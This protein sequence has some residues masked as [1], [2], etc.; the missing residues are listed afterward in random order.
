MR[1]ACLGFAVA[2]AAACGGGGSGSPAA[3][4]PIKVSPVKSG[5]SL[6][7]LEL[8]GKNFYGPFYFTVDPSNISAKGVGGPGLTTPLPAAAVTPTIPWEQVWCNT[9]AS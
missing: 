1:A 3:G 8:N 2:V 4:V 9:A 5:G 6:T 7:V